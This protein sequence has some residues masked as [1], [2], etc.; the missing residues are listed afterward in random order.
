MYF[1]SDLQICR[2]RLSTH[3]RRLCK[4]SLYFR[5][6]AV[7]FRIKAVY[8]RKSGLQIC[9]KRLS[10]HTLH[11]LQNKPI[12]PPESRIFPQKSRIFPQKSPTF[13]NIQ[14]CRN[15]LCCVRINECRGVLRDVGLFCGNIRLFNRKIGLFCRD[16]GLFYDMWINGYR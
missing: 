16:I 8:F 3:S 2:K 1:K 6:R 5:K 7:N 11:L 10:T 15:S 13:L 4:T 12:F 14:I 9:R